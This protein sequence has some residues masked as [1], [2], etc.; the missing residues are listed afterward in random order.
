MICIIDY[1][2]GN[3]RSVE[4]A[5]LRL[6][7]DVKISNKTEDIQKASK[8]VLPGIGHFAKGME[9]LF[10]LKLVDVLNKEVL[11]NKKIVLGI[12]LGMQLMTDHSEEGD[13]NGLGWIAGK[14]LLFNDSKLKIPHMGWNTIHI[15]QQHPVLENTELSDDFYFA[16]SYYVHC[17]K[18][19]NILC[20][21]E[22]GIPFH[23][24]IIENNI[25]GLQFHLEKSHSAGLKIIQNFIDYQY[26]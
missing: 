11:E 20:T 8:L 24:G 16:H 2:M 15:E 26:V 6:K 19:E 13:C 21:T 7:T 14:S 10:Q 4:K 3:L 1:G 9:N 22:Y 17:K 18:K 23:S 12:C 5:F 25:I